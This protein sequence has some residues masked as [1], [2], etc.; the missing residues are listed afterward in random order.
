MAAAG[1]AQRVAGRRERI[2][3]GRVESEMTEG[4]R[5]GRRFIIV[6]IGHAQEG[7]ERIVVQEHALLA[8]KNEHRMTGRNHHADQVFQQGGPVLHGAQGRTGP[9][10]LAKALRHRRGVS[11]KI[12]RHVALVAA[13]RHAE[14]PSFNN[15]QPPFFPCPVSLNRRHTVWRGSQA[16]SIL[17]RNRQRKPVATLPTVTPRVRIFDHFARTRRSSVHMAD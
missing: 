7:G 1:S 14:T 13:Q 11:E 9:F 5:I 15:A 6:L 10:Q 2:E 12:E 3:V 17:C 8:P 16:V 4:D